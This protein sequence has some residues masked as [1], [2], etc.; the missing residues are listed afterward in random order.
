MDNYGHE[1]PR[2]HERI[3]FILDTLESEHHVQTVGGIGSGYIEM[4]TRVMNGLTS[5]NGVF[6]HV[7][8]TNMTIKLT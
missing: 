3:W 4:T 8:F 2:L 5:R 6:P 1:V 7:M